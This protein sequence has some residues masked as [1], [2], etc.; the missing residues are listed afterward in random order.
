[1]DEFLKD[2][3]ALLALGGVGASLREVPSQI[4]TYLVSALSV[5]ISLNTGDPLF[6]SY[7]N[8]IAGREFLIRPSEYKLY[9][10]KENIVTVPNFSFNL[11]WYNNH[12]VSCSISSSRNRV[13]DS[14][15]NERNIT[16]RI[17]GGTLDTLESIKRELETKEDRGIQIHCKYGKGGYDRYTENYRTRRSMDTIFLPA[18]FKEEIVEDLN[19][20]YSSRD[21]YAKHSILWKR[22]YLWY[23]EPGGGKAQP[24]SAKIITPT[25]YK[26]MGDIQVGD[27]VIGH[28]GQPVE[29]LGGYILKGLKM[30]TR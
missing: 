2:G 8:W 11:F 7:Y 6:S 12:L 27:R 30:F 1:M 14:Y 26:L 3:A 9:K 5:S 15:I 4:S 19:N 10:I 21:W 29:V 20:F 22:G 25:G 18:H 28:N 23:G 24:L 17:F 13:D 16:L